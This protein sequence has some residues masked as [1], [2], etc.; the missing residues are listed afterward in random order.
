MAD[1]AV[2]SGLGVVLVLIGHWGRRN[3]AGLT[4]PTLPADE[5]HRREGVLRRG[6]AACQM[7]GLLFVGAGIVATVL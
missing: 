5:R 3:A 6:G 7:V 4:P 1:L 2:W